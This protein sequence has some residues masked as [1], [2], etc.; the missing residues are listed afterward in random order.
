MGQEMRAVVPLVIVLGV[1]LMMS[2]CQAA[3]RG[4]SLDPPPTSL[5]DVLSV[6]PT[7]MSEVLSA[8]VQTVDLGAAYDQSISEPVP[9]GTVRVYS[10]RPMYSVQYDELTVDDELVSVEYVCADGEHRDLTSWLTP[11]E[12][13]PTGGTTT[14]RGWPMDFS[15]RRCSVNLT[16]RNTVGDTIGI[17]FKSHC[18]TCH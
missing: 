8:E 7:M 9:V 15:R 10:H 13:E 1:S 2:G 4:N 17:S 14:Y 16:V 11:V 6:A 5:P 18:P 12:S 3:V